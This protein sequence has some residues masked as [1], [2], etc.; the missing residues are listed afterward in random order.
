MKNYFFILFLIFGLGFGATTYAQNGP[1]KISTSDG[2]SNLTIYPNPVSNGKIYITTKDN[3][4]KEV[5]IY[6][7]LGKKI[8]SSSVFGK[9][10]NISKLTAGIYILKI[11]EGNNSATRKL[12]VR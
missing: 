12:V 2:I 8:L 5:E 3:L 11:R 1:S 10:L 4:T 6:D 9:E 7:V